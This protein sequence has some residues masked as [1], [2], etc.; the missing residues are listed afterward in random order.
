MDFGAVITSPDTGTWG[1]A[2]ALQRSLIKD[3]ISRGGLFQ[4]S[5]SKLQADFPE[6]Y[7]SPKTAL[8]RKV[9]NQV[10]RWKRLPEEK[11]LSIIREKLLEDHNSSLQH[12][13]PAAATSPLTLTPHRRVRDSLTKSSAVC[14]PFSVSS[15]S[16][17]QLTSEIAGMGIHDYIGMNMHI[18]FHRAVLNLC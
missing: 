12:F 15:H 1:L 8:H 3:I 16:V 2:D 13:C 17:E 10:T 9:Q 18:L 11:F 14:F 4:F 6:T 5:L 7:G